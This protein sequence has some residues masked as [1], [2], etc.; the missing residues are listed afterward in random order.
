VEFIRDSLVDLDHQLQALG[1]SHGIDGVRLV[2]R[3]GRARQVVAE[4][5]RTLGVQAVYA[6]HDDEP[7]ALARDAAVR[8][9]LAGED[10]SFYT[11]KD[12]VVFERD[13]V[14]TAGGAV[15]GLHPYKNAWLKKLTPFYLKA[16]PVARH[17]GAL[18]PWPEAALGPATGVPSC[19]T[20]TSSAPTCT[21]C[22]CPRARPGPRSCWPISWT[23]STPTTAR[24]TSRPSRAPAT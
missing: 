6:N 22:A 18:A 19:R 12:H 2:V 23:A 17:A 9:A 11:S 3:H 21:A 14:M 5:A 7:D 15:L 8:G 16:Y 4:L 24:A 20:S 10:V 13:E 1:L